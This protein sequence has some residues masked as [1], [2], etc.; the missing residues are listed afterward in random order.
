MMKSFVSF[1]I[2]LEHISTE[3][4]NQEALNINMDSGQMYG[5]TAYK[6]MGLNLTRSNEITIECSGLFKDLVYVILDGQIV[7]KV[8]IHPVEYNYQLK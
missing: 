6:P 1:Q 8:F 2:K 7:T 4:C 3:K 5:F